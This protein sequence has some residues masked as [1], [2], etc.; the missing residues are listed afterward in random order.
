MVGYAEV[1]TEFD[2][3]LGAAAA[4]PSYKGDLINVV[5]DLAKENVTGRIVTA[6][7]MTNDQVPALRGFDIR[8]NKQEPIH[9]EP[10]VFPMIFMTKSVGLG[11]N[12]VGF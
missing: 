6:F 12:M 2:S 10:P 1:V 9:S 7:A 3:L 4:Y 8:S 11:W 5:I